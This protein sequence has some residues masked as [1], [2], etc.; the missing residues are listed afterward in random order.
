MD[1][2]INSTIRIWRDACASKRRACAAAGSV[3]VDAGVR[4]DAHGKDNHK[5]IEPDSGV[6]EPAVFLQRADLPDDV[7]AEGPDEAADGVAELELGDLREGLPVAD[8]DYADVEEELDALQDVDHLPHEAAVGAEGDVA[9]GLAGVF[10][11]V[12]AQEHSPEEEAAAVLDVSRDSKSTFSLCTPHINW[13]KKKK[14]AYKTA[15]MPK[16]V[17]SAI[18]GPQPRVPIANGTPNGPK[19]SVVIK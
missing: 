10:V 8:Y 2:R 13:G 17:Y 18:P 7:A 3:I 16:T 15:S 11:A 9:V 5:H 19:I 14:R 6:S 4:N 12:E 1:R